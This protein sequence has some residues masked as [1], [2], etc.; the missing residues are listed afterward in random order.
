M[1]NATASIKLLVVD[2]A[3]SGSTDLIDGRSADFAIACLSS[4]AAP[5]AQIA[6]IAE[7]HG[8]LTDLHIL[9]HGEPGALHMAGAVVDAAALADAADALRRI[10]ACLTPDAE[11]LLYGCS[12]ASGETGW[13]FVAD[14]QDVLGAPVAA[15]EAP[16]GNAARGGAWSFRTPDGM[17]AMP[18]FTP[19]ARE[20][21]A[22]LLAEFMLTTGA[23]T[24]VVT[25]DDDKINADIANSLNAGDVINGKLGS[26][27]LAISAVQEVT[28]NATTLTNVEVVK[29][30]HTTGTV[31]ITSHDGTV[32]SGQSLNVDGSAASGAIKWNGAAEGDGS[33]VFTGGSAVDTLIGGAG[34]DQFSSGAG[35][36]ILTG[37]G[38]GDWFYGTVAE[39]NGDT[40]TDFSSAD[41]LYIYG[42]D[43]SAL[44]GQ[45]ASGT[46]DMGS[47]NSLSLTGISA[48]SGTF[49]VVVSGGDS[50]ITLIAP[51]APVTLDLTTGND[52]PALG[53]G[54]DT[55]N[56]DIANSL[57]INDVIDGKGGSD[58][59]NI[60]ASQEVIF[61]ATT[62]T[63]VEVVKI[64]HTSGFSVSIDTDDATVAAGQTLTVD[65]SAAT[66]WI[67][68]NGQKETDGKFN[69]TG[70]SADDTLR[71]GL[72]ADTLTGGAG[73]DFFY[74]K[75]THLAGDTIT[76]FA[77]GDRI[78]VQGVDMSA[79]NGQAA[80]GTID[81]GGGQ[82]LT[83][84]GITAASGTFKVVYESGSSTITLVPASVPVTASL[85]TGHDTPVLG[86]GDDTIT[87]SIAYSLNINDVINGE[88]GSDTLNITAEQSVTFGANTL[89]NVETVKISHTDGTV[90]ITTD[91]AT[92]ASGQTLTVDGSAATGT[93]NW[94]GAAETNGTFSVTGGEGD[95]TLT[96]GA[97]SDTLIGGAGN[98]TLR[99]GA[100]ADTLTGGAG[101]DV[102][103]GSTSDLIDDIITDFA[104]G[105]SVVIQNYN[106]SSLDGQTA[107]NKID[108]GGG[109]ELTFTGLS[110]A[111]GTFKAVYD[112]TDTTL[113]LVA[114]GPVTATLT[115]GN[116]T[117]V[118]RDL[119]D[120]INASI[121]N[122]LNAGDV[123]NGEGG[124]DTLN[125]TAEQDV[126]FGAN[127]LTN[128]ETVTIS[129]TS[130]TVKIVTDDATVAAGQ[131]LT[132]D[133]SKAT[134]TIDWNGFAEADGKFSIT[135][136][137]GDDTIRTG[138]GA[139][140]LTGGAGKDS[141]I[142]SV[143]RLGGDTITDFAVGDKITVTV[144]D[145]T[146]LDGKA[147]SG[148][149]DLGLGQT[150][151]LT[152]ITAASG[153][154]SVVREFGH[155][156]ITLVAPVTP[157]STPTTPTTPPV[158]VTPTTPTTPGSGENTQAETITNNGTTP[159]S[160]P[161]VQNSNNNG[162]VVTATLP[163]GTSLT[164]E[165]PSQAQNP[166]DA[167]GSLVTSI[168]ARGSTSQTELVGGAQTFLTNLAETSTLDVRTIVPTSTGTTVPGTPIIISGTTDA[169][170]SE[171]FVI[172]MRSMPAGSSLQL[173]NIEFASIIGSTTITGGAGQNYV[174]ADD[175]SQYIVLGADDD[176]IDGGAGNDTVGSAD[177]N[178]TLLGGG[179]NDS[180]F[181]GAG[182][183]SLDGGTGFDTLDLTG[184]GANVAQ[185]GRQGDT[186]LGGDGG[187]EL[188]GGKGHDS[189]TGGAGD[190]V[191]Y[192]GQGNDTL[193]GGAGADLFVLKGFDANFASA[194][195][196]PT[197]TDFQQGTD[198]LAVE[199]VTLMELQAAIANQAVTGTGVV[200]EVAGAT[201]TFLG[202]SQLTAAD[203]DA[204]FYA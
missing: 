1:F 132:V 71:G 63:N 136:G 88:G 5:L 196:T 150:L 164:S 108:M 177:G 23:D 142:G 101:N 25:D 84:T 62:M 184:G 72:G 165:G 80:S 195:L 57:N 117:P 140:T 120:T 135:G 148:T 56:A 100:G 9:S 160:A 181:G 47:G 83:L 153:T 154:F 167:L 74:G 76:D 146:A 31:N 186:V 65:G 104:I 52:T 26:D 201:L 78:G 61:N 122:S 7:Q 111:S 119:N 96:G 202:I 90:A 99:G 141:F 112:G 157:P 137:S 105:D 50:T 12:V 156:Y 44:D 109:Q 133:G 55:I 64:S 129:H 10:A 189:I 53:G 45:A 89:T 81:L 28:F 200:I 91:D 114:P 178:D 151:T 103:Q 171:A 73:N 34:E 67:I 8:P 77:A 60:T 85:T 42:L 102:F 70:G 127:T 159:G 58:T 37:N 59:L 176:Y 118:L 179:G 21:F 192:S 194:I 197:I 68:W 124:S 82:S 110:A 29:I 143:N 20:A 30:S 95:D 180:V 191:I 149:I 147:A 3:L 97:G 35:A 54:N 121:A 203:I 69:L 126:T 15:S 36:D 130:G 198:R 75:A 51:P 116:D 4:E 87:A 16:V 106:L 155:S 173:D 163:G 14:L 139:D 125:I 2:S 188:R 185:G 40:V 145:L 162:N 38:G 170:Q 152:G 22:G 134:G 32:A 98:D 190:D 169:G 204:A 93:I 107:S 175:A 6:D 27:S 94:N 11:V 174:V 113:T 123:I 86:G 43:L 168:E 33:F 18:A 158:V 46:I 39:L 66:K 183:D 138:Q 199:H 24:P 41:T 182:N 19:A 128:V 92:V 187:D 131:T 115:T 49:K 166:T 79:L 144:S 17:P 172:D 13:D 48:A 161:I 193:T